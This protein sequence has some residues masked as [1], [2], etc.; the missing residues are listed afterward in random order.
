M[1]HLR[2]H[3]QSTSSAKVSPEGREQLRKQLQQQLGDQPVTE[4]ML[5]KASF[6]HC[7]CGS[8]HLADAW[9]FQMGGVQLVQPVGLMPGFASPQRPCIWSLALEYALYSD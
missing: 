3:F 4:D 8:F 9:V 5:D 6:V 7:C 1:D 2:Q